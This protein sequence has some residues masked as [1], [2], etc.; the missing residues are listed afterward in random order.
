MGM[1]RTSASE[2]VRLSR[3]N[4]C[5]RDVTTVGSIQPE[6]LV[7]TRC[8]RNRPSLAISPVPVPTG[9][10]CEGGRDAN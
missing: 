1:S 7:Y 6:K 5:N 10:R 2:G 9:L 3:A 8:R 4:E